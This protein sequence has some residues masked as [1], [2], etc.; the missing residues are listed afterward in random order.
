MNEPIIA[1]IYLILLAIVYFNN[2]TKTPK[3]ISKVNREDFQ[4]S[5]DGS[6]AS[7]DNNIPPI[8]PEQV[9]AL[10]SDI[11][12]IFKSDTVHKRERLAFALHEISEYIDPGDFLEEHEEIRRYIFGM[13]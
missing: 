7:I 2:M 10:Y 5:M 11:L 1:V 6:G 12:N 9:K 8:S 13:P 3:F 4:L